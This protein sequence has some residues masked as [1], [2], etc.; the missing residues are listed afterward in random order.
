MKIVMGKDNRLKKGLILGIILFVAGASAAS[1]LNTDQSLNPKTDRGSW[2]YVGGSGPGNYSTIQKAIDN[3]S[4]GDTVFVYDDSSPYFERLLI[5]KSINLEGENN[6]TTIIEGNQTGDVVSI[7]AGQ[8]ALCGFTVR[9]SGDTHSGISI[10]G[11]Q[12]TITDMN[13]HGNEYGVSV[14]SSKRNTISS[15]QINNNGFGVRLV[16][17]S[18]QNN[19]SDNTFI[20]WGFDFSIYIINGS[21]NNIIS[22][23]N[24]TY[25]DG[26]ALYVFESQGT[27]I[28]NNT[29]TDSKYGITIVCANY[30]QITD[31]FILHNDED[32][33]SLAESTG[34]IISRNTFVNDGLF[35]Y[36]A[37]GNAVTN[38][39]VNGKAQVYLEGASSK[40][41]EADAGQIIL[42][43]CQDIT[44]KNQDIHGTNVGIEIWG[45]KDINISDNDLINNRRNL[46]LTQVNS[47]SIRR[48]TLTSNESHIFMQ[49]LLVD[50]GQDVIVSENNI[51][52]TDPYTYILIGGSKIT[53]SYNT[54]TGSYLQLILGTTRTSTISDNT[55]MTG[56]GIRLNG[57]SNTKIHGNSLTDGYIKVESSIQSE[58][59]GNT[60]L[61]SAREY[62]I[63]LD[64]SYGSTITRNTLKH[65]AGGISLTGSR[66][67]KISSNNIIDCG[68]KPAWFSNA[69][70]NR[71]LRNY[72]GTAA[73][74]PK[75]IHG[76]LVISRGWP[77]PDITIPMI[78]LDLFPRLLPAPSR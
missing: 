57:C 21:D 27:I 49:T 55:L 26:T 63:D 54:L 30:T 34:S 14:F 37:F 45:G 58:I 20:S 28:I 8:V 1:A 29:V 70:L 32:G 56:E 19:I 77:Y 43:N 5:N 15:S 42:I 44:I 22:R 46:Y 24:L 62:A 75:V 11:D 6:E 61:N 16:D 36:D 74:L 69:F 71:W 73:L 9:G 65:C 40:V 12:N 60:V 67:N 78:T 13:I 48:N 17:A 72:W 2:L 38:N 4:N 41:L 35:V 31:N 76:E 33:L 64:D 68:S 51:S 25:E 53:F 59:S 39:T 7:T 23:N 18:V 52:T 3:A 50:N 47:T 66:F 10:H